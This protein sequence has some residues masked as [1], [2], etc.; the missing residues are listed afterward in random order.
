MATAAPSPPVST[1]TARPATGS[2]FRVAFPLRTDYMFARLRAPVRS[3]LRALSACLWL[4]P[5]GAPNLGT[6]FSYAAPGQPNELS[7]RQAAA[8]AL[9]PAP[10]RWQHLCVTWAASGGTWSSFQDGTPRGRGEGLAPGHPLRPHGVLVLGQEQDSLGGRFDATQAFVGELA[11]FHLWS[12]A[13]APPEVAALARCASPARGDL[14]A[15]ARAGLELH[16]GVT[17]RPFRPCS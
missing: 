16:G 12:R 9:A 17:A 1:A 3:P 14:L 11:E 15:W 5:G 2:G 6:P 10:G 4:R 8:L 7:P 13:L